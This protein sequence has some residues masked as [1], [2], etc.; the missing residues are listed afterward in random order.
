MSSLFCFILNK[1]IFKIVF[2]RSFNE[3]RQSEERKNHPHINANKAKFEMQ[4][5]N[6]TR[7]NQ[8]HPHPHKQIKTEFIELSTKHLYYVC[9]K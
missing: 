5:K 7:G 6:K 1:Y 4:A 2:A 9:R 3:T 8:T